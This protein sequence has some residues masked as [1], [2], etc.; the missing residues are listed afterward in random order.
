MM[1]HEECTSELLKMSGRRKLSRAH[2]SCRLFWRGVPVMSSRLDVL[3]SLTISDSF[4]FSFLMRWASSI[5]MYLQLNFLKTA[6]SFIT[7]S[8][9]VTQTSHSPGIISSRTMFAWNISK[10]KVKNRKQSTFN[11]KHLPLFL[12]LQSDKHMSLL[13]TTS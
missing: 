6:R 8:Y 4:D 2:N 10:H 5:T 11:I 9:E 12:D 3:N 7:I 1:N 13:G